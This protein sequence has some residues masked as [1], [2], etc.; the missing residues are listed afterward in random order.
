MG[1][2]TILCCLRFK[3]SLFVAS[4]DSQG[5]GGGI[6]RSLHT[7]DLQLDLFVSAIRFRTEVFICSPYT[8]IFKMSETFKLNELAEGVTATKQ[9]D[10]CSETCNIALQYNCG[11]FC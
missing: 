11:E 7:G 10:E 8:E 3:I 4:Y 2:A 5:C 6:Q 1:L 9:L